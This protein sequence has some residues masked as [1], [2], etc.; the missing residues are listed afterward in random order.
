MG[1]R[2]LG[3]GAL[4]RVSERPNTPSRTRALSV[5]YPPL[6]T[7]NPPLLGF[8]FPKGSLAQRSRVFVWSW[9]SKL[10][11][12]AK[13][14]LCDGVLAALDQMKGARA[15][16]GAARIPG[17]PWPEAPGPREPPGGAR[18]RQ[19]PPGAALASRRAPKKT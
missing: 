5:K 2:V 8:S 15:A 14:T 9:R 19:E 10:G 7:Q 1:K 18:G 16:R 3:V 6:A 13:A 17:A 11:A 12:L 4:T